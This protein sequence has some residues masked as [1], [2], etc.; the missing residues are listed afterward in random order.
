MEKVGED[1]EGGSKS[2]LDNFGVSFILFFIVFALLIAVV[3]SIFYYVKRNPC[4]QKCKDRIVHFKNKIF[5]NTAIRY[6]FLNY[7]KLNLA[8]MSVF[9]LRS[10]HT[11]ELLL[12]ILLFAVLVLI[13]VV[14]ARVLYTNRNNLEE[15]RPKYGTLFKGKSIDPKKHKVWVFPLMFFARRTFFIIVTLFFS[16]WPAI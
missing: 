16:D 12:A 7:L 14:L 13:P 8:A 1:G 2:F 4:S 11:L 3:L 9:Y 5:W 6:A 10:D 15:A